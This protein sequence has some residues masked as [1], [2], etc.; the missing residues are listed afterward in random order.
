MKKLI[1]RGTPYLSQPPIASQQQLILKSSP[2]HYRS[3]TYRG[4]IYTTVFL[5]P[6]SITK[7]TATM[8]KQLIYRGQ[9]YVKEISIAV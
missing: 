7:T 6:K 9:Y 3:L 5:E 4:V 8:T 1:Y 2:S